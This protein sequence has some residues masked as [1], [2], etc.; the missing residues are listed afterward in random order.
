[1]AIFELLPL[2]V[3]EI[4]N[5]QKNWIEKLFQSPTPEIFSKKSEL[6]FT[7]ICQLAITGG[8]P[9]VYKASSKKFKNTWFESYSKTMLERDLREISDYKSVTR[10]NRLFQLLGLRSSSVVNVMDL[11]RSSDIPASSISIYLNAL[12]SLFL[13]KRIPGYFGNLN[14][15]LT[16]APKIYLIDSG[17]MCHLVNI[18]ST[19][20]PWEHREWG[21]VFE[22]FVFNEIRKQLT[23]SNSN[24][25]MYHYRTNHGKE[26]DLILEN[27]QQEIVAVEIK[28]S[29]NVSAHMGKNFSHL[30]SDLKERFKIGIVIYTGDSI[31]I[32][33]ENVYAIPFSYIV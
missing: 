33:E 25:N 12:E 26:I 13:I 2:S 6:S 10:T 19:N 21:Q 16:K 18:E 9:D 30:K 8:Y 5:N 22:T 20:Q 28:A 29:Q 1:M 24:I 23:W 27:K 14:S 7:D 11:A 3:Q 4:L 31:E 15:R 32:L 17:L